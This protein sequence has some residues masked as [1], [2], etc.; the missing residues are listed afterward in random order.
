MP[1]LATAVKRLLRSPLRRRHRSAEARLL[2][3][4]DEQQLSRHAFLIAHNGGGSPRAVQHALQQ[5]WDLGGASLYVHLLDA[6]SPTEVV[7]ARH[8]GH[9]VLAM[10]EGFRIEADTHEPA[11]N[12][13]YLTERQYRQLGFYERPPVERAVVVLQVTTGG[14]RMC[15]VD[16]PAHVGHVTVSAY[17]RVVADG[18]AIPPRGELRYAVPTKGRGS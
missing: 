15:L 2:S 13:A 9:R 18:V 16:V 7:I 3:I 4:R 17:H 14:G 1:A 8:R 5:L 10:G 12:G 11:P 6:S